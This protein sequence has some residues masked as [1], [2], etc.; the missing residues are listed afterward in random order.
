MTKLSEL[1]GFRVH[2]SQ[3]MQQAALALRIEGAL[4]IEISR[5]K[6]ASHGDYSCNLAMQLAKALHKSP[7]E[8]AGMLIDA[9]PESAYVERTEVAGAGFINFFIR[10]I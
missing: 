10:S 6:Q 2:L 3:L 7:R 1:P 9:M 4:S 8:I 5:T